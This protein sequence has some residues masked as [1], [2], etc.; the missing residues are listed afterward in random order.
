MFLLSPNLI[1]KDLIQSTFHLILTS[2]K[3]IAN[4]HQGKEDDETNKR[5]K[6]TQNQS[7]QM[8]FDLKFLYAL[9]DLKSM[10]YSNNSSPSKDSNKIL[11][12][13]LL[14]EY[15]ELTNQLESLVD[16]FDYDICTPFMQSN[17]SKAI[18]RSTVIFCFSVYFTL[19]YVLKILT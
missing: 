9:F 2:Y 17:I 11:N 15:K 3:N 18:S 12:L 8:L 4:N 1:L 7:L 14:D 5:I 6:L 16:P 10:T 19:I 13:K